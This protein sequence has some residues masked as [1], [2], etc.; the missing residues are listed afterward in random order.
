MSEM[1]RKRK[2][3]NRRRE[4]KNKLNWK[5]R[6]KSKRKNLLLTENY[7]RLFLCLFRVVF[8]MFFFSISVL[9]FF[10]FFP[11]LIS[12]FLLCVNVSIFHIRTRKTKRPCPKFSTE[13]NWKIRNLPM[14]WIQWV[15]TMNEDTL[16]FVCVWALVC[17]CVR[18]DGGELVCVCANVQFE[19]YNCHICEIRIRQQ[20]A[21]A[22]S[23][24]DIRQS[25]K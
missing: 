14:Y 24:M 6:V 23:P 10:L 9:I 13:L 3:T 17:Q 20:M 7:G 16:L 11:S 12:L 18:R 25:P 1:K 19:V 8:F 4:K 21:R 15:D 5:Q 2:R 22:S